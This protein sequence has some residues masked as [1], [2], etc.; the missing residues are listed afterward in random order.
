ME[1]I[2]KKLSSELDLNIYNLDMKSCFLDI[3][4]TGLSRHK[5]QVY[6]VGIIYYDFN[7]KTWILKQIF[8]N[9]LD[10]EA[11]ILSET[12]NLLKNHYTI[13]NYNGSSFDI[14]FLNSRFNYHNINYIIEEERSFD[15]YRIIRREKNFLNLKN[16]KL[17]TLEKYLGIERKDLYS[18]KDCIGFYYNY[19]SEGDDKLK[20][21]ILMHNRDDLIYMLDIISILDIIKAKKTFSIHAQSK[22]YNYDFYMEDV[23]FEK[24]FLIVKGRV[25]KSFHK[26]I[27]HYN[28]SHSIEI[29]KNKFLITVETNKGLINSNKICQFISLDKYTENPKNKILVLSIEKTFSLENIKKLSKI[30]IEKTI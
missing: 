1:I 24:N 23:S 14:P 12:I 7:I 4:T 10:E 19:L 15:I 2:L 21:N 27:V 5:N 9:N 22:E 18:G 11:E 3:E 6:L 30:L 13:I 8:A 25:N 28:I 20:D 16:L 26:P 29:D 17:E